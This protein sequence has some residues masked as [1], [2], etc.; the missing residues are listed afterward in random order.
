[1]VSHIRVLHAVISSDAV[2][3]YGPMA[4]LVVTFRFPHVVGHLLRRASRFGQ[5]ALVFGQLVHHVFH[6]CGREEVRRMLKI[7]GIAIPP[8]VTGDS[9]RRTVSFPVA[10]KLFCHHLNCASLAIDGL[11]AVPAAD[12]SRFDSGKS[13]STRSQNRGFGIKY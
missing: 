13:E 5:A 3:L 8:G 4:L 7:V 10:E 6:T 9:L 11:S 12:P 2:S 1:M